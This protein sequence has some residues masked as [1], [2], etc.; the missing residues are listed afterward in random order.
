MVLRTTHI[1]MEGN[2][3]GKFVRR[4][5]LLESHAPYFSM[6]R[7]QDSPFGIADKKSSSLILRRISGICSRT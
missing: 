5:Q 6:I 2:R 7:I 4:N 1:M 3:L